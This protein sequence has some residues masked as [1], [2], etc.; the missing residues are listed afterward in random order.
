MEHYNLDK[1]E[2]ELAILYRR[3]TN[4][5]HEVLDR[6]AYILMHQIMRHGKA[7]IKTLADEFH[8]DISTVSRQVS[9][10]EEKG[11]VLRTPDPSD[12]R[13]FFL[14]VTEL[15]QHKFQEA[16]TARQERISNLLKDWSDEEAEQFGALLKKLNRTFN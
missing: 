13:A 10:L 12:G 3:M 8:L 15:G 5:K 9:S 14:E 11:Y 1:I 4:R 7:G 2:L 16:R 6:S